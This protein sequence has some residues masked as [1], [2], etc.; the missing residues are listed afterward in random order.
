[1]ETTPNDPEMPT[2]AQLLP[3]RPAVSPSESSSWT[4]EL[5]RA[6]TRF[7]RRHLARGFSMGADGLLTKGKGKSQVF[8]K[9]HP[10]LG[11]KSGDLDYN[12][13]IDAMALRI[14]PEARFINANR[15]TIPGVGHVDRNGMFLDEEDCPECGS[16]AGE[17]RFHVR[18]QSRNP[19]A[20]PWAQAWTYCRRC[21]TE[22]EIAQLR[23]GPANHP[24]RR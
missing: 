11:S 5:T 14:Y 20:P 8:V 18:T 6:L 1:M 17:F 23:A 15:Y 10:V 9:P 2:L 12:P 22:D 16:K 24:S 21:C 3:Q 19:F 7:I 13:R 4:E